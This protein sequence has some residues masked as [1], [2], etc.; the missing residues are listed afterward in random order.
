MAGSANRVILVGNLGND[1][2][3]RTFSSG[4]KVA[5]IS[6]ATSE[7]WKDKNSGERS[8]KTEWHRV[9]VFGN[10]ADICEQYLKK[11]SKVY[12]EGKLETRSW[13]QDGQKKYATEV[14]VRGFGG[15]LTMLDSR[16]DSQPAPQQEQTAPVAENQPTEDEIPF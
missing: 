9:S 7:R 14:I 12:I 11:G 13:E 16:G 6:V 10:L 3:I 4:D 1:P 15:T 5:N 8:E 2:D